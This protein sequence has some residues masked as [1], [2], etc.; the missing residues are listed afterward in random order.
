MTSARRRGRGKGKGK[1]KGRLRPAEVEREAAADAV[2][3]LLPRVQLHVEVGGSRLHHLG[4]EARSGG[5][6]GERQRGK[7]GVKGRG[8]GGVTEGRGRDVMS[9]L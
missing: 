6:E 8:S 3:E 1:G 7:G 2:E 4:G 5:K 9:F